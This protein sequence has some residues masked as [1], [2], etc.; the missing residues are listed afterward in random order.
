MGHSFAPATYHNPQDSAT[1]HLFTTFQPVHTD[2]IVPVVVARDTY[3]LM[4][5]LLSPPD[6]GIPIQPGTMIQ[7]HEPEDL[8]GGGRQYSVLSLLDLSTVIVDTSSLRCLRMRAPDSVIHTTLQYLIP[9]PGSAKKIRPT[10]SPIA[11]NETMISSLVLRH[12]STVSSPRAYRP[13]MK[14]RRLF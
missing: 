7:G 1:L 6:K 12:T 5:I 4:W 14:I 8:G 13:T 11:T 10:S 2:Y 3:N 9:G